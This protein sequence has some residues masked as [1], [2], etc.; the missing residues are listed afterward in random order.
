[1]PPQIG[2]DRLEIAIAPLARRLLFLTGDA[3]RGGGEETTDARRRTPHL[4]QAAT[5]PSDMEDSIMLTKLTHKLALLL[6][7]ATVV[8]LSGISCIGPR[9]PLF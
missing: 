8:A 4:F 3:S 9:T 2:P 6:T 5:R 1:V 7:S